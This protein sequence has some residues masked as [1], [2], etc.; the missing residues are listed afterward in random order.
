M[1]E[2]AERPAKPGLTL[3]TLPRGTLRAAPPLTL[4]APPE[5]QEAYQIV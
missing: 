1:G 3:R 5:G 2:R 4:S